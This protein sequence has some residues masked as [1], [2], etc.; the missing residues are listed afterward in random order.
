MG[1]VKRSLTPFRNLAGPTGFASLAVASWQSGRAQLPDGKY[2]TY[3]REGYAN[4]EI[5]YACVEEL[6]TSAAEPRMRVRR[7]GS[8]DEWTLD[9]PLLDLLRRPN[10]F[11]DGFEFWAT[12][13]MHRSIAGNAYALKVRSRAG[14]V[15]EL[16]L[17]RP[18]R[19]RIVPSTSTYIQRYEYDT[20]GEVVPIPPADVVH[21]KAR[22]PLNQFYGMPPLLPISGRI[23]IDNFMK[24]FV[25]AYFTNAG[26]PAGILTVKQALDDALKDEIRNRFSNTYG[27]PRGW[28]KLLVLE[29]TEATFTPM[30]QNLGRQGLVIPE[31][32]RIAA[33]RI[34]MALQ[35]PPALIGAD[36]APT[37]Y[38]ALEMVQRFFWDN[39]LSPLYKELSGRITLQLAPD[40][41]GVAE[42]GFDLSDVRALREDVDKV[43]ARERADL[44]AGGITIEEF[45]A[46]TGREPKVATGTY[47]IPANLVPVGADKVADDSVDLSA[48]RATAGRAEPALA[49]G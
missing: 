18:D 7:Q 22:N 3:A 6:A 32:D 23:D 11:L 33:R 13:I 42:V 8:K 14:K 28:H 44:M 4:N 43:H 15:V 2:E 12:V 37:S 1:L 26:V 19:V 16:W 24:D 30:T 31:L 38:A 46:A 10:A 40:F 34:A 21:F 29:Q 5:V 41:P 25:K 36:D 20:G 17:M 39:T 27:G 35:V 47:L 49:A 48:V 9:H 45:R